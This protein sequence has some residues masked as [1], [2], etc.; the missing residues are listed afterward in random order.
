MIFHH[1]IDAQGCFFA[2]VRHIAGRGDAIYCPYRRLILASP[3]HDMDMATHMQRQFTVILN[4]ASGSKS[5]DAMQAGVRDAMTQA[6]L[7]FDIVN[8]GGAPDVDAAIAKAVKQAHA[9]GHV[10]VAAGG[11]GTINAVASECHV[12]GA[13]MGV[14]PMGTFN[15]FARENG[16]PVDVPGAVNVLA[17]GQERAVEAG[18][19]ND[20]LF[21]VN[22][23]FGLYTTVIRNREEVKKRFG[24]YR[25]VAVIS[26][27]MCLLRGR[28]TFGVEI[29][30]H[31]QRLHRDTSMVFVG[32][33]R[34]QLENL[35][36]A[37]AATE[38]PD[39]ISMVILKPVTRWQTARLLLRGLVR[40]MKNEER[41]EEFSASQIEV[42]SKRRTVALV[43]DGE[44]VH[45]QTPLRFIALP[46]ALR[47]ICPVA[48]NKKTDA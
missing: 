46:K 44:I 14:I 30:T 26:A 13:L 20:K 45:L 6:G 32:N 2:R 1:I 4:S 31:G 47:M 35:G 37:T 29:D 11:D 5:G 16:I 40:D 18:M 17:Q 3:S 9:Q 28:Q 23:S 41:L 36:L 8:I 15:Y 38:G 34:M 19:V 22:A 10:I 48:E 21:L 42:N 33:N 43:I 39:T 25:P 12:Q 24:R 27:L 7:T